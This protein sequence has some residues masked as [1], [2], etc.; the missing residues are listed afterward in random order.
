MRVEASKTNQQTN[1]PAQTASKSESVFQTNATNSQI[2]APVSTP[3]P[4]TGAFE[5]IM[6]EA[7]QQSVR[8]E[9]TSTKAEAKAEN[10]ETSDVK[11]EDEKDV[12]GKEE[13]KERDQSKGDDES[14]DGS[15]GEENE[16]AMLLASLGIFANG[17]TANENSIPAARQILHVAD[18]ERIVSTIRTLETKNSQQVLISLKN[19]VL[20]GL[21]IKLTVD[22]N[23]KLK[24]EFIALNEKIREQ[25]NARKNELSEIM[26]NRGVKF[27]ELHVRTF[28][29]DEKQTTEN[30]DA[31]KE[32]PEILL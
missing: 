4:T 9:K 28:S 14:G 23:G 22:E 32:R 11:K 10:S 20:E 25:I 17:K 31:E 30:Q 7:R 27:Q 13:L 8:D 1:K 21:Q 24:A 16:N 3:A 2:S 5:K 12:K 26:K 19:S 29:E 18:L 15:S 6:N